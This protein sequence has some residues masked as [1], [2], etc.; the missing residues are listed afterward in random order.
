MKDHMTARCAMIVF[1]ASL[2]GPALAERGSDGQLNLLYWQPVTT[3]NPYISSAIKDVDAA[4]VVLEPLARYDETGAIVPTLAADIPTLEN[5]G[6]AADLRSITWTLKPGLTWSDGSP[7]TSEDLVFTH[8]YCTDPGFG[9]AQAAA[10]EGIEKIEAVDPLTVKVM[11]SAPKPFPYGAFVGA[12]SPVLQKAQFAQ[13]LGD[14][15]PTCTGQNVAPIGTGPFRVTEFRVNDVAVLE[16]NPAYRDPALPAFGKLVIKGGGD[17]AAAAR[18]ILVTSEMDF[19][20]NLQVQ[21]DVLAG[22]LENSTGELLVSFGPSVEYIFL[23]QT[24][25]DPALGDKRSTVEGG[26]HPFLTDPAVHWALSMA[27][28]RTL[29]SE[30][31]YGEAG[32]PVCNVVAAP[33]AYVSTANDACLTQD[34]EGANRLL[35]EAGW[36][37]GPDGIREK[38]GVRLV[39][40]YLTSTNPVR[41]DTQAIVKQMWAAIGVET[42]L[43]NVDAGVFFG[44]DGNPDG[45]WRFASDVH[46][47]MDNF[48]GTDPERYLAGRICSQIPSAAT[49]WNGANI[50]RLCNPAYDA[51]VDKLAMTGPMDERAAIVKELNDML[52]ASGAIMPLVNRADVSGKSKSLDGVRMNSWDSQL[53][54]I[55]EWSRAK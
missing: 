46:M 10:F 8:A 35:D 5:G 23:N 20:W 36:V 9:C 19:A 6:V 25:P 50:P 2:A 29:I 18:A 47:Y 45:A 13:C 4:S 40:D 38:D 54:N 44:G 24:N 3:M 22:M 39:I 55:A 51:L 15:A 11:F 26:P 31:G 27:L 34:V 49:N 33:P 53:W 12:Q 17:P 30:L 7:V 42:N 14:R 16:A 32:R 41:Q 52:V 28:D 21:P 37:K 48:T 43:R 1:A